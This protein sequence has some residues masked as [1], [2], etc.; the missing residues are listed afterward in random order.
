ML[1]ENSSPRPLD[2]WKNHVLELFEVENKLE[3]YVAGL[4]RKDS[5][6]SERQFGLNVVPYA[7]RKSQGR[8]MIAHCGMRRLTGA[9]INR[10]TILQKFHHDLIVIIRQ[11][12]FP[13]VNLQHGMHRDF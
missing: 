3:A 2:V 7:I 4:S 1:V 11:K 10:P 6:R 9:I 12:I 5:D 13:H 8:R